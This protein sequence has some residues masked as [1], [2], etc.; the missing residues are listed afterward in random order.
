[1]YNLKS[2]ATSKQDNNT[3]LSPASKPSSRK[4]QDLLREFDSHPSLGTT[5]TKS[6][7]VDN[8]V[9]NQKSLNPKGSADSSHSQTQF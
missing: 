3:K 4:S 9:K 1:M 6:N 7:Y 2:K 8:L 5:S